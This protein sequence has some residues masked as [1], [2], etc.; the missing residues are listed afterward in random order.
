MAIRLKAKLITLEPICLYEGERSAHTLTNQTTEY[1][2][3]IGD[4]GVLSAW[5]SIGLFADP[6]TSIATITLKNDNSFQIKVSNLNIELPAEEFGTVDER[7]KNMRDLLLTDLELFQFSDELGGFK[8]GKMK[9]FDG[10]SSK[11]LIYES[12]T[13]EPNQE[14]KITFEPAKL[15]YIITS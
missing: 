9:E 1:L 8:I 3:S 2:F 10:E 15:G 11:P 6:L 12:F 4:K 7:L 13:L 14:R 5:N